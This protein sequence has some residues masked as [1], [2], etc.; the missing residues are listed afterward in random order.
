MP[1][2]MEWVE[3][4]PKVEGE[5]TVEGFAKH[6]ELK[7]CTFSTARLVGHARG[8]ST[9]EGGVADFS[10]IQCSML[11]DSTTPKLFENAV[12]GKHD[13]KLNIKF[14]RTGA[15]QPAMYFQIAVQGAGLGNLALHSPEGERPV[16]NFGITYDTIS[17][18]YDKI[19][20]DFSGSPGEWGWNLATNK[21]L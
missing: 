15:G 21:K 1:I 10:D 13:A 20:D 14:V 16:V 7:S 4:T 2:L 9:R 6:S 11:T 18:K 19:G 17:L 8:T 5:S 3:I 12:T